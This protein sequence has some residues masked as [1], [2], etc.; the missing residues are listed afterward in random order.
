MKNSTVLGFIIKKCLSWDAV[1]SMQQSWIWINC[2]TNIRPLT[3]TNFRLQFVQKSYLTISASQWRLVGLKLSKRSTL[4]FFRTSA[5]CVLSVERMK[6]ETFLFPILVDLH[7]CMT[8]KMTS[9]I[10]LQRVDPEN[11]TFSSTL[12]LTDLVNQFP[13]LFFISRNSFLQ[14]EYNAILHRWWNATLTNSC[15]KMIFNKQISLS[16]NLPNR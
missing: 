3:K 7:K 4:L 5:R 8:L 13:V 1:G 16:T 15:M 14:T 12:S 9:F 10:E 11:S 2:L 6:I